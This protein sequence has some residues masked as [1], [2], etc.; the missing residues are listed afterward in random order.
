[1]NIYILV[2][3]IFLL[4]IPVNLLV[5]QE[6][7]LRNEAKHFSF[8]LP[9]GWII[10]EEKDEF[11]ALIVEPG[12][13]IFTPIITVNMIPQPMP[14]ND[15]ELQRYFENSETTYREMFSSSAT[16]FKFNSVRVM[17]ISGWKAVNISAE[18]THKII[19]KEIS[20]EY[21]LL[22]TGNLRYTITLSQLKSK[23]NEYESIW[24]QVVQSFQIELPSVDIHV[25]ELYE[26]NEYSFLYPA[27]WEVIPETDLLTL[28]N[29]RNQRRI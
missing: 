24:N 29:I 16:E 3:L 20:I 19:K 28:L 12:Q 27:N 17:E 13:N 14:I 26:N 5:A 4:I 11:D 9:E 25:S 6:Y 22:F 7:R 2:V 23:L 8:S 10:P 15:D 1:M 18:Y 21:Y